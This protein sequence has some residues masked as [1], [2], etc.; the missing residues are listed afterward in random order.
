MRFLL[1]TLV[2][3]PFIQRREP[4]PGKQWLWMGIA[5]TILHT[6]AAPQ[7]MGVPCR[8][9]RLAA[10]LSETLTLIQIVSCAFVTGQASDKQERS[11]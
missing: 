7:Q 3:L 10:F 8:V 9:D 5:G 4:I 1:G 6:A 2:L 11:L